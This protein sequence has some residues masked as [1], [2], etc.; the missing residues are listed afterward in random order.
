MNQNLTPLLFAEKLD[1]PLLSTED[2]EGGTLHGSAQN[3]KFYVDK[4]SFGS[5]Q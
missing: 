4:S 2:E 5:L 3:T 1:H